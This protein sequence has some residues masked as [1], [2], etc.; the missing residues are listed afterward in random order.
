MEQ[1]EVIVK[2]LIMPCEISGELASKIKMDLTT[3]NLTQAQI[4]KKH[5]VGIISVNQLN[6][7]KLFPLIEPI[8]E[9][10]RER[11][12]RQEA[13]KKRY[14]QPMPYKPG[15][16][17]TQYS[18]GMKLELDLNDP[19]EMD[20]FIS[21]LHKKPDWPKVVIIPTEKQKDKDWAVEL[22]RDRMEKIQIEL[23]K[24]TLIIDA[25]KTGDYSNLS[26]G[27]IRKLEENTKH[28]VAELS[29]AAKNI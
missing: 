29:E 2:E 21:W 24:T 23:A 10:Q 13:A 16:L 27:M 7:G 15:Q 4:G 26:E 19:S 17:V 8:T 12:K 6:T 18:T 22:L 14:P 5:N 3:S 11:L 1:E 25:L 9:T 20:W 28:T